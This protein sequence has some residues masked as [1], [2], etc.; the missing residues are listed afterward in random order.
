MGFKKSK[1]K[2]H[3]VQVHFQE[4]QKDIITSECRKHKMTV[5]TFLR[6]L[7]NNYFFKVYGSD[8]MTIANNKRPLDRLL[9]SVKTNPYA[10]EPVRKYKKIHNK[11]NFKKKDGENDD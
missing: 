10:E 4:T 9:E 1:G 11:I 5:Q 3:Y 8:M 7:V 6:S 2:Y